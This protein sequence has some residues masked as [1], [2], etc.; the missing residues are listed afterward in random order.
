MA[1]CTTRECNCMATLACDV[2]QFTNSGCLKIDIVKNKAAFCAEFERLDDAQSQSCRGLWDGKVGE[3]IR[4]PVRHE[5][6][7][8]SWEEKGNATRIRRSQFDPVNVR[9]K[10]A[11]E[12]WLDR[13]DFCQDASGRL[14]FIP[15]ASMRV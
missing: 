1:K 5:S 6:Q 8:Y 15:S 2:L 14:S 11:Q 13:C 3:N 10:D 7:N 4:D 9:R 12:P